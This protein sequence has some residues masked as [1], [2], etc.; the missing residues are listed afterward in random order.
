VADETQRCCNCRFYDDH[1]SECRLQPPVFVGREKNEDGFVVPLW[2]SPFISCEWM[3]WC[4]QWQPYDE[5][6]TKEQRAAEIE[7]LK[8]LDS[9]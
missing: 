5:G 9:E 3:H 2:D 8:K 4:G 1:A 6:Q 7:R